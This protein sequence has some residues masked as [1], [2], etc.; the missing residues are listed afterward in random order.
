MDLTAIEWIVGQTGLAGVAALAL[1]MLKRA[2]EE[3]LQ[4]K[5]SFRQELQRMY[6]DRVKEH[7]EDRSDMR[8]LTLECREVIA[9]NTWTL[10]QTLAEIKTLTRAILGEMEGAS[11]PETTSGRET[12]RAARKC[13]G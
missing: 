10:G 12:K 5:Q 8:D 1:F 3:R 2:Y 13:A 4:D 6:D 9:E 11:M 7:G